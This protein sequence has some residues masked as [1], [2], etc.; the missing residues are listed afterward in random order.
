M[1]GIGG[2]YNL[3]GEVIPDLSI[4]LNVINELIRHR[5][6]DDSHHWVDRQQTSG[7]T[8]RRLS[9][10]DV[11]NGI[12]PMQSSSG[13]V[14]SFNGEIYNYRELRKEIGEG[15]FK[16]ES[17]TEVILKSYEKWGVQCLD[18]L[19]GMFA[20]ALWDD[21]KGQLFCARDRFGIK[22]FYYT[23]Q[24]DCLIFASE[25]KGLIPFLKEIKTDDEAFCD[26]LT[27]Q[28]CLGTE[29][30][31]KNIQQLEA[32]HYLL[33][34]RGKVEIKRYW[35]VYYH[36]DWKKS[37]DR[38]QEEIHQAFEES[39]QYHLRSDVPL[40][41]Y[42][43]GGID[44]SLVTTFAQKH[45]I[46]NE[47][48]LAYTGTFLEGPEFDESN[49]AKIVAQHNQSPH[50]IIPITSQDFIEN[51]QK[52]IYH[53]DF[54]VA[55]PGSFPQMIVAQA[56]S[57]KRKV[58]LGGQGGD[59]IFGGYARYLIAYFEQCILSAIDG[60]MNNG[61]FVVTYE[62][63]LPHLD[64]LKSYKPLIKKFWSQGLF[65]PMDERYFDLINR[66]GTLKDEVL[67]NDLPQN[68]TKE[69]FLSLF[70]STNVGKESYFDKMTHF[71]FKTLLP[72]LLHVED[73]VS[74][75]YGLESRVPF[76]DHPL[77]E[78]AATAPSN[79]K[80][81]NGRLKRLLKDGFKND[82]PDAILKREDKMG[83]PVPLHLWAQRDLKDYLLDLFTKAEKRH[84]EYIDFKKV[85]EQF[86]KEEVFGRN[87]WAFLCIELWYENFHDQHNKFRSMIQ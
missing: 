72:A 20:F 2:L 33:A 23:Q 4:K 84:R 65:N 68:A 9:I 51:I 37:E 77:V 50:E 83:F 52:L 31:F 44:S 14:I 29:T 13:C 58:V 35:Q 30:L 71:D 41:S 79:I 80:F 6:P 12:Q 38:F 15:Q 64:V 61:K 53:L 55:G 75:A 46:S 63:I 66:S 21:K 54:P 70:R 28:F 76:L 57:K 27:F 49:Y 56:I 40:A 69:K 3:R 86:F 82:L 18:H 47:P 36:L 25:C 34:S 19:R 62:S 73:R 81:Q 85:K 22:P 48:V 59:E 39:V 78:L 67:W 17:D 1:C 24:E 16:T 32:G 43:S 74:M 10:I 26:Y 42:L 5:G 11:N 8:H 7:L 45:S 87:T 60:T